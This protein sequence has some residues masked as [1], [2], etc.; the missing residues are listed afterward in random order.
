M[1]EAVLLVV[2][3]ELYFTV[4]LVLRIISKFAFFVWDDALCEQIGKSY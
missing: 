3:R 2:E 1:A 4:P